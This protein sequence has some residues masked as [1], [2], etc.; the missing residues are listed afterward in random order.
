M[1]LYLESF[2][3]EPVVRDVA[4]L[5]QPLVQKNANELR[6]ICSAELGSMHAD[7]TKVRQ[8]LFNLLSNACKFTDHGTVTLEAQR[9]SLDGADWYV[10]RITDSG[11]GMTPEQMG[12]LFQP[13]TQADASTMRK[14]GGTGLGLALC[15]RF[16]EMMGGEVS[17]SSEL[18]HGSHFAVRLPAVVVVSQPAPEVAPV[19]IATAS[20]ALPESLVEAMPLDAPSVLVIDD[21]PAARELILRGL[22]RE[23]FRVWTATS[24]QEGVR[25]ARELRPDAITLDVFMPG[26]DGWSVLTALKADPATADI[27]IVMITMAQDKNLSYALG[28]TEYLTKPVDRERLTAV[29]RRV[30]GKSEAKTVLLVDR[31]PAARQ[32][33]VRAI[34][35]E[36]WTAVQAS[37]AREALQYVGEQCPDAVL[38]DLITRDVDGFAFVH[39]L[40]EN[41]AWQ[42][43]PIIVLASSELSKQERKRLNATVQAILGKKELE[44]DNV[45]A[46]L[47]KQVGAGASVPRTSVGV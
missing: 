42:S 40:R 11:I 25:L 5:I 15:Q 19:A 26:D 10:F 36:H 7:L 38:L 22:A 34:E 37:N 29:V 32:T 12:K 13:F 44:T 35:R 9:S 41:P 28:A 8:V 21:D 18:G 45:I 46:E 39:A 2:E 17:V 30:I 1:D 31:D 24:A 14:Y 47:R 16:S 33:L 3:V 23:R 20:V 27:P 6:L 43:I 4:A